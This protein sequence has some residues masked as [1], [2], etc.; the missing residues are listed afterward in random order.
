MMDQQTVTLIAVIFTAAVSLASLFLNSRFTLA[1]ERT[2]VMWKKEVD[3]LTELEELAGRLVEDIGGYQDYES[4]RERIGT[5]IEQL[6]AM[7]GRLARYPEVRHAVRELRMVVGN[8]SMQRRKS[9]D[10]REAREAIEPAY[11][12]LLAECDRVVGPR[13]S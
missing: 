11:R 10:D 6:D 12:M 8:L 3:R 13:P 9:L 2:M 7:G 1:R 5:Q 4:I